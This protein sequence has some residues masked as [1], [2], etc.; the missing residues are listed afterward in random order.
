M[1]DARVRR[2]GEAA[3][4]VIVAA[5]SA[6]LLWTAYKISGFEALSSPGAL[7]MAAAG[8]ML[9]TA[10]MVAAQTFRGKPDAGQSLRRDIVPMPIV[11]TIVL[12]AAYALLLNTL[13][14]LPTSF[15]FV[16]ILIR[17]LG[18]QS[19]AF[20]AAVSAGSILVIYLV[21]RIIFNVI[22]PEGIVP[23]R[24]ILAAISRL[25]AGAK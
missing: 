10:L 25:F 12:V 13:G 6:F 11:L 3:F 9:V 15:L 14:F 17:V 7:P 4:A 5:F 19:L 21:F 1:S 2:P 22:M 23:E 16:A 8:T 18:G 24:E 20:C